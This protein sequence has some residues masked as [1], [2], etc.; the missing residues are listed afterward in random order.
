[1][2]ANFKDYYGLLGI[3]RDA[4][5]HEVKL[6][7]RKL[8]REHHPDVAKN[9]N[10]SDERFKDINEAN[11]VLS[12]PEK[13]KKYDQLCVD[14]GRGE[15]ERASDGGMQGGEREFHFGGTG[16]SDFF[17]QYFSGA[18]RYG[19]PQGGGGG[20]HASEF[21]DAAARGSMRGPDIEGEFPITLEAC[22]H[23]TVIP[24]SLQMVNRQSGKTEI[25]SF[26]VRIPAGAMDGQRIR[27]PGHG[28]AGHG[29]GAAGDLF[30]RLRRA[31]HP[32]FTSRE[33]DLFHEL[34]VAPWEA[35]LGAELL[36]PT[37]DGAIN[38]HIPGFSQNGQHLRV[39][40]RGLPIGKTGSR[41][42]F[43]VILQVQLP[44]AINVSERALWEKLQQNA[45]FLRCPSRP[46]KSTSP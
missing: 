15:Q 30:L 5:P 17:E 43:F 46:V 22:M 38:L 39:R 34:D 33:A 31:V 23:G 7:Y 10:A 40:G 42:D 26:K 44:S 3:A 13:R 27:V 37:L 20:F 12:D 19:F 9:K 41:G 21:S 35:V 4:S 45:S 2:G 11:E 36:V 29:G 32:E 6:A 18:N 8:A 24:I 25:R 28:E 1:M 14:R 16:F